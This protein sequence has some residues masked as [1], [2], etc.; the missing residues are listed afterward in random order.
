MH[1][2]RRKPSEKPAQKPVEETRPQLV[3]RLREELRQDDNEKEEEQRQI[4]HE[5]SNTKVHWRHQARK[6]PGAKSK[7]EDEG[8][9]ERFP[10][11][12]VGC[13]SNHGQYILIM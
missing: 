6:K 12:Q 9:K 1:Y 13:A 7:E 4:V 3:E 5:R 8:L 10:D 2:C 11:G